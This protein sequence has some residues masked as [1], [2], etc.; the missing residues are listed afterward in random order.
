MKV[1]SCCKKSGLQS[2]EMKSVVLGICFLGA[3]HIQTTAI[4]Y[5]WTEMGACAATL[6]IIFFSEIQRVCRAS[7]AVPPPELQAGYQLQLL[8]LEGK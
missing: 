5:L 1:H 3:T 2:N 6:F 7:I 8:I 4:Q